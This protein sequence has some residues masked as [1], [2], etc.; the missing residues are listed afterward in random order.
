MQIDHNSGKRSMAQTFLNMS[1][2]N[3]GFDHMSG[4]RMPEGMNTNFLMDFE[5]FD[6]AA[7]C[8]LNRS[9][10]YRLICIV[11]TLAVMTQRGKHPCLIAVNFPVTAK[12][13]ECSIGQRHKSIFS[14]LAVMHVDKLAYAVNIA[15][16]QVNRLTESQPAGQE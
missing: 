10:R 11:S 6:S 16:L 12:C 1:D 15:D 4:I 7:Q 13:Q 8:A 2:R 3:A 5:S 9:F 14:S